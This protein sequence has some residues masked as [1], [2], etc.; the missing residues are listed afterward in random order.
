MLPFA[1][2]VRSLAEWRTKATN[3]QRIDITT[4]LAYTSTILAYTR[5]AL[6]VLLLVSIVLAVIGF[7]KDTRKTLAKFSLI[8]SAGTLLLLG[9]YLASSQQ[10]TH[11]EKRATQQQLQ[12]FW[13]ELAR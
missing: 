10:I 2:L 11:I 8:A 3:P 5:I 4:D 13:Q 1:L 9:M 6:I 12:T 7:K